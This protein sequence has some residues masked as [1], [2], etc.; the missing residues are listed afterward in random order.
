MAR[1]R[2]GEML[3][4]RGNIDTA[5]LQSALAHQRRWGGRLG[6]AI[7]HLGFMKESAMLETLSEQLGVPYVQIGERAIPRQVLALVPEKLIRTRKVLP[8]ELAGPGRRALVVALADPADLHVIDEIAFATGM[9]VRPALASEYDVDC[10]I[11]RLLDGIIIRREG[12]FATREDAIELPED[13]NPLSVESDP[14]GGPGG[15]HFLN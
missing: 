8:L 5:Q 11:S 9:T 4:K 2:I 12:G 13:T 10:A 15:R 7:V 6:H 1:V 14:T 3:V